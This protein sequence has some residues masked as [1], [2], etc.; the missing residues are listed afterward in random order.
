M[1]SGKNVDKIFISLHNLPDLLKPI[2]NIRSKGL[3]GKVAKLAGTAGGD[4][5]ISEDGL[6]LSG[7]TESDDSSEFLYKYKSLPSRV[8]HTYK[9]LP[10]ATVLFETLIPP[11][12]SVHMVSD[13]SMSNEAYDLATK[14]KPYIGEEITRAII[15]IKGNPVE[16]NTLIIYELSNRVMAEQIF[17]DQPGSKN[18]ILYFQPDEQVKIPVY[19]TPYKGLIRVLLPGFSSHLMKLTLHFMIN[20]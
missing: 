10:S 12:L 4:I 3:A 20:I 18:E 13:T 19:K 1:A 17:L 6:V 5:Y 9:I 11:S 15:N 7:Y 2:L 14:I 16:D 8:F